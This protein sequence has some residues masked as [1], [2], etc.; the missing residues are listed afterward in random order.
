[1][2]IQRKRLQVFR[3]KGTGV[4]RLISFVSPDTTQGERQQLRGV[5]IEA[6]D[7]LDA[8]WRFQELHRSAKLAVKKGEA[9]AFLDA[10]D[11]RETPAVKASITFAEF[12]DEWKTTCVEKG[13]LRESQV[14]SDLSILKNHLLPEFGKLT[15]EQLDVRRVDTYKAKK[16]AQKHQYGTGYSATSINNHLSVLH[17]VFEKAIEYGLI[18]RN[19]VTKRAWMKRETTPEDSENWWTP[20]EEPKAFAV[21]ETWRERYPLERIVILTQ[22]VT[23]T[24][25]G[26]IRAL[27][28]RDLDLTVPCLWIRRSMARKIVT[29]PKNKKARCVVLPQQIADELREW[30][31][32][33]EGQLL[34]P[35]PGGGP[36]ANNS[37]NRWY[38]RLAEEAEI[39]PITSHGARHTSGSSY[40]YMG[41]GQRRIALLLGHTDVATTAR[42]THGDSAE[43]KALVEAR[44]ARLTTKA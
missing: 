15:L 19:P 8:R 7:K 10:L 16:R 44:W 43:M 38:R 18:D 3:T 13:G 4:D 2:L 34:F 21:L 20:K 31:L 28:K 9:L 11:R 40:D 39:R 42:Y 30:M 24:R 22:S 17:R 23:S 5:V 27:E 41:V 1:M 12:S 6:A 32:R 14:E 37:L 36:L 25:F 26:E 33:T 35:G 29:T